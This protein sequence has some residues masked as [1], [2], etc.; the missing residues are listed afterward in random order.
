VCF[1][2]R[3]DELIRIGGWGYLL[4]SGGGG[5]D[6]GR[7]ALEAVLRAH[8]GRGEATALTEKITARLGGE[9]HTKIT[10]IYREGKPY[11]ASCAPDVFEAAR[12]GD[13]V[14]T[15]ILR[16]NARKLAE[17]IEAAWGHLTDQ[18]QPHTLPIVM[19]GGISQRALAEKHGVPYPALRDKSIREG[20]VESRKRVE[21]KSIAAAEQKI[22]D[23][24]A[25]NVTL[26][27]DIKRA[28]LL[29]LKRI[30]SNYPFDAT[31]VRTRKGDNTL[32]YRIKDLTSALKDLTDDITSAEGD[33]NAPI[34]DLIRRLDDECGI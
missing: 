33:K 9:A 24:T 16:R 4:D 30:E 27:A 2:R 18:G 1:L 5:Y 8:D 22:A 13:P 7:D 6:I 14:A 23:A 29:R 15:A 12:E 25:E 10:D 3:G 21:S 28:L 11:I 17:Y 20:W 26:A 31:E 34:Y 32:I 19:G